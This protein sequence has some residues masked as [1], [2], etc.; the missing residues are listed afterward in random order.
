MTVGMTSAPRAVHFHLSPFGLD[1]AS[2]IA[3]AAHPV[4][5]PGADGRFTRVPQLVG[6]RG[7]SDWRF[8][9]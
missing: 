8:R 1:E 5:D 7:P 4:A 6:I 3:G 2:F 9:W